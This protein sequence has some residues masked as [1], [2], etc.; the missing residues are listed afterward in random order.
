MKIKRFEDVKV[1]DT[2]VPDP[3]YYERQNLGTVTWKGKLKD[4]LAEFGEDTIRCYFCDAGYNE[5]EKAEI[6]EENPNFIEVSDNQIGLV[7]YATE[8]GIVCPQEAE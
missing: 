2:V 7:E 1:G 4:A 6:I 3:D 8:G 5:E